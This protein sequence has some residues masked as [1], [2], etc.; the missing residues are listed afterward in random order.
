MLKPGRVA[1]GKCHGQMFGDG[2][3]PVQLETD[4]SERLRSIM[5]RCRGQDTGKE[6]A[7]QRTEVESG[8]AYIGEA[9]RRQVEFGDGFGIAARGNGVDSKTGE[10]VIVAV[11][12]DLPVI[13]EVVAESA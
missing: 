4:I 13:H 3:I 5:A 2:E 12:L 7:A 9:Q 6:R 1:E 8:I 11:A 10:A